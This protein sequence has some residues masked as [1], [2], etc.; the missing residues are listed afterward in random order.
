[1]IKFIK[2]S[3]CTL[4]LF[5]CSEEIDLN[6]VWSLCQDEYYH[7]FHILNTDTLINYS[8]HTA[9]LEYPMHHETRLFK[10]SNEKFYLS[11]TVIDPLK[12]YN[13]TFLDNHT[14]ILNST[15]TFTKINITAVDANKLYNLPE[16][17]STYKERAADCK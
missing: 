15:D 17:T 1:M 4:L 2:F 8:Q 14:F 9:E 12:E 3:A 11:P 7:E 10:L 5:S 13:I 16:F 6:G